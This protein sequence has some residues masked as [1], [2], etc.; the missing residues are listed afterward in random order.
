[1]ERLFP[2]SD[3]T[4]KRRLALAG[5]LRLTGRLALRALLFAGRLTLAGSTLGR[6][7]LVADFLVTATFAATAGGGTHDDEDR[8]EDEGSEDG[9]AVGADDG[10]PVG[11]LLGAD[12]GLM[13]G[14]EDG[15]KEGVVGEVVGQKVIVGE[16][17]S[18]E[19][20]RAREAC[21]WRTG[22]RHSAACRRDPPDPTVS[23][24]LRYRI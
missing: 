11:P 23:L 13:V 24:L 7:A 2:R 3:R 20:A 12:V 18:L 6:R 4:R 10:A 22:K 15:A 8:G 5:A 1:M 17:V 21:S 16:M 19:G 9:A 14:M